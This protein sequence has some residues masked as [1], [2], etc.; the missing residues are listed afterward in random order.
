MLHIGDSIT[1]ETGILEKNVKGDEAQETFRCRLV[2]RQDDTFIIDLPINEETGKTTPF[3]VGKVLQASFVGIDQALYI[4]HTKIIGR[5]HRNV[6]VLLLNDPGRKKHTRIQRRNYARVD[7]GVNAAVHPLSPGAFTPF[8][9]FTLNISGGGAALSLPK[10]A[11]I[12]EHGEI[13][14]SFVL[15]MES[16][17]LPWIRTRASIVR[18]LK[19]SAFENEI[20]TIEFSTIRDA[21]RQQIIQ[22]VFEQ[23]AAFRRSAAGQ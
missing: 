13:D 8:T 18:K 12:P 5:E 3:P 20:F 1:L 11:V 14:V 10:G 6:P 7:A 9:T 15:P 23:Q 22:Y 21:D 16:G 19:K 2:D 17:A 4:F